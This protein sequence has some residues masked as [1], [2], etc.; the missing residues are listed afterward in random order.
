MA[1]AARKSMTV[2]EFFEWS[3]HQEQRFELVDGFPVPLRAM[4]GA[5]MVHDAI[6][7]N[8]IVALGNQLRG[9]GC[10]PTTPDA[11]LR[12]AIKRIRRPDVTIE[13]APPLANSYEARNPIAVIEVLSPT[14]RKNDRN[15]KLPEYMRHPTLRVIVHIDPDLMDVLVYRRAA[16]GGWDAERLTAPSD[17][18]TVGGTPIAL[19]LA[20]I[21]EDVPLPPSP[22]VEEA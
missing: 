5:G 11:G 9:T 3:R 22:T 16:D 17:T 8:V 6:A 14:T 21:Y 12:T 7:T 10:R 1:E 18:V 15:E 4:S 20:A 2:E 13:C 19:T